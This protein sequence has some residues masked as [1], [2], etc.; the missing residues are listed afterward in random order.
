MQEKDFEA[1]FKEL[2]R[3]K[4]WSQ[5]RLALAMGYSPGTINKWMK[6]INNISSG[7]AKRVCELLQLD[8]QQ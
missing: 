2:L 4:R 7:D 1:I 5:R 6:G 3:A 8:K